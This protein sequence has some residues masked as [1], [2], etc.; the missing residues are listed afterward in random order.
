MTD[1]MTADP[2]ECCASASEAREYDCAPCV[3]IFRLRVEIEEQARL[4]GAGS[5][6]EARL[7]A[8]VAELTRERDALE[9]AAGRLLIAQH[10]ANC[11]PYTCNKDCEWIGSQ[12]A[13]RALLAP[14]HPEPAQPQP[15]SEEGPTISDEGKLTPD[16]G[17]PEEDARG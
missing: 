8:R 13:I 10:K 5:E 15:P 9:A 11:S 2:Y 1:P 16:V 17:L 7:M 3:E 4:N 14:R 12:R 6:R